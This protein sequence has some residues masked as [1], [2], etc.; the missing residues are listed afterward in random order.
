MVRV[1]RAAFRTVF[2]YL[3]SRFM[4]YNM[5]LLFGFGQAWSGVVGCWSVCVVGEAH[6]PTCGSRLCE[7]PGVE[8]YMII[9]KIPS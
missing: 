3:N 6:R 1:I 9:P 5:N 2:P 4:L 7:A 8:K